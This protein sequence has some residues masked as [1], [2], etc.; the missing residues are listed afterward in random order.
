MQ[1]KRSLSR[2]QYSRTKRKG[3]RRGAGLRK[4]ISY[5]GGIRR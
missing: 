2:K 1:T 3:A 5:R 4:A